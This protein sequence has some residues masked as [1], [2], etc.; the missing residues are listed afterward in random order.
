MKRGFRFMYPTARPLAAL[1][2]G[3][4]LGLAPSSTGDLRGFTA[5]SAKAEREWEA[6]FPAI[7][8]PDSL[9]EYM[10]RLS[11]PPHHGGSPHDKHN[12]EWLLANVNSFGL[13]APIE[14][15]DALLPTPTQR[16]LQLVPPTAL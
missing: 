4:L 3:A 13:D 1:G 7:P 16:V 11:A 15:I 2:L 14:T 12:A 9:R 10:R 5:E 6:K 8:S